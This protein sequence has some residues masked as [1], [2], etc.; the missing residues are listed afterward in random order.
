MTN[1]IILNDIKSMQHEKAKKKTKEII[2]KILCNH[3]TITIKELR[4]V[5]GE[6]FINNCIFELRLQLDILHG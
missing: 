6:Q 4:N 3:T 5:L 1:T 2:S